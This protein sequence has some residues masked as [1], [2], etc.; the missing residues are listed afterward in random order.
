M[1]RHHPGACP[2]PQPC[3]RIGRALD[4]RCGENDGGGYGVTAESAEGAE[5]FWVGVRWPCNYCHMISSAMVIGKQIM[6]C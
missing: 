2:P 4:S 3:W 6:L 5:F 1:A